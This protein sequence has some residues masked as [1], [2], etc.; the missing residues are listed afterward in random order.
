RWD[1]EVNFRDEKTIFGT[2]K[3]QVR[4]EKSVASVPA[5]IAA[6]YSFL[7]LATHKVFNDNPQHPKL[8]KPLWHKEKPN[9][10]LSTNEMLGLLRAQLWAKALGCDSFSGFVKREHEARSRKNLTLSIPSTLFYMK[11]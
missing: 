11:N 4:N 5:F 2:G 9:Q 6:A 7:L 8:P 10:R 1:I 3:A